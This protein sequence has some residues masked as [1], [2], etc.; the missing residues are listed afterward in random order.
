VRAG[1]RQHAAVEVAAD[2]DGSAWVVKQDMLVL[3]VQLGKVS[4]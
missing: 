4:I 2:D 1:V 3:G